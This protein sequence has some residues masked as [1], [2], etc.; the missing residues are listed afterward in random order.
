MKVQLFFRSLIP[1]GV[2]LGG[3]LPFQTGKLG[4][5]ET[6]LD[7]YVKKPDATYSWKL[8]REVKGEGF[9]QYVLDMKSQTWR[10]KAEVNKPIWQHW[11]IIT[12]PDRVKSDKAFLFIGGG[13]NGGNPPA[14]G[15]QHTIAVA[16]VAKTVAVELRMVPNQTLIFHGDGKERKEDDLIGY[17]WDQYLKTGD[18]TWPARLP[19]VKSAVRAMDSVQE[20]LASEQGGKVSINKFVVS[21]GSKRGWTTW[22][23]AAVDGRVEAIIPAVIDVLNV[24]ESMRHHLGCY[25][26]FTHS[27]G[28]YVRHN[29]MQRINDPKLTKLHDIEDPYSYRDRLTM[30]KFILNAGGDQFFCPDSSQFYF[31]ALKGEKYLRYVPNTDHS[32]RESDASES[33]VSYYDCLVNGRKRPEYQWTFEKDGSIRLKCDTPVKEVKLWQ[34]TNPKARDFRLESIGKAYK[35]TVLKEQGA[36]IY[37]GKIDTPKEGWTAFFV[38]MTH[39]TGGVLPLKTTSSVRVLPDI[40]PF[41]DADPQKGILEERPVR[42]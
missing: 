12:K 16:K 2:L 17:T 39:E 35:S 13:G 29:I 22:C 4:A 28:D 5:E 40:L 34:A 30:P 41:K 37:V 15:D 11:V 38:E 9:T 42:K 27:V 20:F 23:T 33:L 18:E 14:N 21:G 1:F 19:M 6:A 26:F 36:G 10:T 3:L 25:G 31:D 7:R 8:V 24:N 32:L